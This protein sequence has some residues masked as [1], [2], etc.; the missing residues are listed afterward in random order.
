MGSAVG[1]TFFRKFPKKTKT[2]IYVSHGKNDDTI[3]Y[4][5]SKKTLEI[6]KEKGIQYDYNSFNQ[7]HG[8]NQENLNSFLNWLKNKY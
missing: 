4:L 1:T 6:L 2:S 5:E 8:V 3:P 7:G